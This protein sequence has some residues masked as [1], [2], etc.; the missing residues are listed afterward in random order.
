MPLSI[1]LYQPD[2]AGNAGAILRLG[3]CLSVGVE[4]IEPAGFDLSDRALRRAGMNYLEMA[5]LTRHVSYDAFEATRRAAGRRTILFTTTADVDY[6]DIDYRSDDILLFGR[7]SAGVPESVHTD[8][9]LRVRIAMAPSARSLN[10]AVSAAMASG[11]AIRQLGSKAVQREPRLGTGAAI[12]EGGRILLIRRIRDP[13]AGA[14]GL[15]GGKVDLLE[16]ASA[17]CD[18]EIFEETGLR[19]Q[20]GELLCT[21][22]EIVAREGVHWFAPVF[23]IERFEGTPRICEPHKHDGLEW[24]DLDDLPDRLTRPTI[25]AIVALK[26]TG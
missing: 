16:T 25:A 20:A 7:E 22:D 4:I 12:L 3:A 8:A 6:L 18:R 23:R 13:E 5:S 10:L 19:V 21:V 9:D 1:A 17:A 26:R 11:E 15:P 14:W 2:I 24:F